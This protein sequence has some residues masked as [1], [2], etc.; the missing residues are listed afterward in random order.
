MHEHGFDNERKWQ[1]G[2]TSAQQ[3]IRH[4]ENIFM[5]NKK[6]LDIRLSDNLSWMVVTHVV[7]C[8]K[9]YIVIVSEV[10]IGTAASQSLRRQ[11]LCR[12]RKTTKF[13]TD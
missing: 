11:F 3:R 5:A 12:P 7:A 4:C 6:C 13:M 8:K 9:G 2:H 10:G 1:I